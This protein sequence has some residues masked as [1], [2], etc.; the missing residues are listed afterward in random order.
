MSP[1]LRAANW[2]GRWYVST[3]KSLRWLFWAIPVIYFLSPIDLFPDFIP[4]ARIDDVIFA[5]IFFFML[6][7]SQTMRGFFSEAKRA[8]KGKPPKDG[9]QS[10]YD[11]L[12][13]KK[14]AAQREIKQ[15]YRQL[16]KRYHPD[17]FVHMGDAY[18]ETA[19]RKTQQIVEAYQALSR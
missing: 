13:V 1:F 11:V 14:G 10:P 6:E 12:G 18:V 16:L 3:P 7:R 19:K 15:A 8:A 9:E 5:L 4:F 17:K 2:L